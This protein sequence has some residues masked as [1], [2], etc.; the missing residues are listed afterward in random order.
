MEQQQLLEQGEPGADGSPSNDDEKAGNWKPRMTRTPEER[1]SAVQEKNRRAQKRFRERQKVGISSC[2][3][4]VSDG[5]T[6]PMS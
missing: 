1:L 5:V 3:L 2:R 4:N 6:K